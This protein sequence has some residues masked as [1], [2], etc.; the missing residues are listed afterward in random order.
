MIY[1]IVYDT[2]IAANNVR[3]MGVIK[4]QY[5][6]WA[7]LANNVYAVISERQAD[8][9]RDTLRQNIGTQ[10]KLLVTRMSAPAAWVGFVPQINEWLRAAYA[11]EKTIKL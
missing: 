11:Q 3:L 9:I 8:E 5:R 1:V 10:D 2:K 7:I 4:Q 6:H